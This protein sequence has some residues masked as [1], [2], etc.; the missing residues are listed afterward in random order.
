MGI[1]CIGA[2]ESTEDRYRVFCKDNFKEFQKLID[3]ADIIIGFNLLS[4]D[5]PLC[6]A[7]SIIVPKER[8]YDILV[9]VWV[10]AGLGPTF[11]YPSHIGYGLGDIC[12]VNFG[13]AK[14]GHGAIAPVQ[15]QRGEIGAVIDYCLNDVR[16]TKR[17]LDTILNSGE[18]KS[19]INGE[20]LKIRKPEEIRKEKP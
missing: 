8:C 6:E 2:Y 9:E 18:L 7:H 19:P 10:A 14:T 3:A 13:M 11:R 1:S 20:T 5:N 17:V 16:L 12:R 4:F 15:W